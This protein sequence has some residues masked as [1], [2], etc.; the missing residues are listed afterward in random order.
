MSRN[1][2]G[3]WLKYGAFE[4]AQ[5]DFERARS[6]YERALDVDHRN[7]TLWLKCSPPA[8]TSTHANPHA[9]PRLTRPSTHTAP[10]RCCG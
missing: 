6:V 8:R 2:M 1:A 5:R 3:T 10:T 9:S 7:T 4:E